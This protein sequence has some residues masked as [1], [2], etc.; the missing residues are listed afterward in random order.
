MNQ[1]DDLTPE[2]PFPPFPMPPRERPR[3]AGRAGAVVSV[4]AALALAVGACGGDDESSSTTSSAGDSAPAELTAEEFIVELEAD[5]QAHIEEVV[6]ATPEC[7]GL[8]ADRDFLLTVTARATD[9]A[10]DE[11]IN[12]VIVD[13]CTP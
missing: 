13:A 1:H 12:P 6:A 7:E 8:D 9:L 5:K 4:L 2:T 3:A 10:P 11:P